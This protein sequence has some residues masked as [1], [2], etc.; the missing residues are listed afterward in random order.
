MANQNH[1][2]LCRCIFIIRRI[3][4][5]GKWSAKR[6]I[7]SSN[8]SFEQFLTFKQVNRSSN[9]QIQSLV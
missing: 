2:Y 4:K 7:L 3:G 8:F 9:R 5:I 6:P 1:D